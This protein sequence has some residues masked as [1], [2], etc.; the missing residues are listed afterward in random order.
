MKPRE[1]QLLAAIKRLSDARGFQP[2][3]R[4]LSAAM[5]VSVARVHQ[6]VIACERKGLITREPGLA[7]TYRLSREEPS[8]A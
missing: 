1:Q 7:R 5:G 2:T 8:H 6:L 3:M 4:E